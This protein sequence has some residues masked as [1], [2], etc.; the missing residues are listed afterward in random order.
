MATDTPRYVL[1][2]RDGTI[3]IDKHYLCDPQDLEFLPGVVAGLQRLV[4]ADCRL[5]VITNQSGVARGYFD[6]MEVDLVHLQLTRMLV[7]VGVRLEG[8]YVCPHGP[9]DG[10][11]CRKPRTGLVDRAVRELDFDPSESFVIGDKASDIELGQAVGATT[12]LVRTGY[13]EQTLADGKATPD[14]VVA[15]LDEAASVIVSLM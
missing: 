5:V 10:C 3:N 9:E 11:P 2:D 8:I 12:F 13:G 4:G 1:L 6:M 7:D 15:D 14:H